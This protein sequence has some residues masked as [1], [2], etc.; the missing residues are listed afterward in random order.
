[1]PPGTPF[2]HTVDPR[3]QAHRT[4]PGHRPLAALPRRAALEPGYSGSR[5]QPHRTATP[6][7]RSASRP[8]SSS[9]TDVGMERRACRTDA[10]VKWL[11]RRRFGNAV[12]VKRS[13]DSK[14]PSSIALAASSSGTRRIESE[15][16]RRNA[17]WRLSPRLDERGLSPTRRNCA[18]V[19]SG[20]YRNR[21][22][23][24]KYGKMSSCW[25]AENPSARG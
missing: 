4:R 8:H 21:V 14:R 20:D 10:P 9:N 12:T 22:L 25:C 16:L 17:K 2:H 18:V 19:S 24:R 7:R 23:I 15:N 11:P 3:N 1:M 6:S 5:H 13:R